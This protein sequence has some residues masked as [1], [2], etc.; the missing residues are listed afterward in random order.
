[1]KSCRC[2]FQLRIKKVINKYLQFYP[3]KKIRT[4]NNLKLIKNMRNH[5]LVH[6]LANFL[7]ITTY[8]IVKNQN[9]SVKLI[10]W[11]ILMNN[12]LVNRV[13]WNGINLDIRHNNR[14]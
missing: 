1:M 4:N 7:R 9:S 12:I 6:N 10:I 11:R 3:L 5:I 2:L 13:K 8:L 14:H